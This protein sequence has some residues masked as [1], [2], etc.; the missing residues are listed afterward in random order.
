MVNYSFSL[1]GNYDNSQCLHLFYF[2]SFITK[3]EFDSQLKIVYRYQ[4][5]DI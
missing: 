2:F 3:D 1:Q 4:V 5:L